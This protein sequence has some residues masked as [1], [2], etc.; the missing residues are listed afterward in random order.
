MLQEDLYHYARR[1]HPLHTD[2]PQSGP[3]AEFNRILSEWV[4]PDLFLVPREW[5]GAKGQ[6]ATRWEVWYVNDRHSIPM[7]AHL[8]HIYINPEFGDPKPLD[9]GLVKEILWTR[10][11]LGT[12][13]ERQARWEKI[14]NGW[15]DAKKR[16]MDDIVHEKSLELHDVMGDEARAFSFLDWE[17]H[18][19]L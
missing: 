7:S 5:K 12:E 4:H 1:F 15:N 3:V 19:S 13:A 2:C 8:F 16:V 14:E 11:D 18:P 6:A 10:K 17:G 9:I